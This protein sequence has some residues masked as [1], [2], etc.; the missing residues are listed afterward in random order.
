M[1][2]A[3]NKGKG[4]YC[5]IHNTHLTTYEDACSPPLTFLPLCLF[6]LLYSPSSVTLLLASAVN[7]NRPLPQLHALYLCA[8]ACFAC[9]LTLSDD[10]VAPLPPSNHC[11]FV[12][13]PASS[14][15]LLL[16]SLRANVLHQITR[17]I[18]S[19]AFEA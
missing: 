6:S 5:S 3:Y 19:K 14:P 4:L 11:V 13:P 2:G 10:T 15:L 16:Y 1:G 7:T 17:S 9:T 12:Y 18:Y 8:C